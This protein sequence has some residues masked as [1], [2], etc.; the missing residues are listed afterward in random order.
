MARRYRKR[1]YRRRRRRYMKRRPVIQRG[2]LF[3]HYKVVKMRASEAGQLTVGTLPGPPPTDKWVCRSFL[4]NAAGQPSNQNA[5]IQPEG[6]QL[7]APLFQRAYT[8]SSKISVRFLPSDIAHSGIGFVEKSNANLGG[9]VAPD[10]NQIVANK[11][12]RYGFYGAG[13]GNSSRTAKNYTFSTK[14]WF[15][16]SD[17]K[18]N[19]DLAQDIINP[20]AAI[21]PPERVC[22]YNFGW[23]DTHETSLGTSNMDYLVVC[24][25]IV[26]FTGPRNVA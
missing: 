19:D 7:I 10:I 9:I 3:G 4:A 5:G 22:Y 14:R 1:N 21:L 6:W 16:V 17:V 24:D 26:L 18:D 23:S 20:T 2:P 13:A 8:L 11:Y 12:C 25:Y 15:N